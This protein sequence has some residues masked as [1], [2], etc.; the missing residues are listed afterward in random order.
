[1]FI[2]VT[3]E[4]MQSYKDNLIH[5]LRIIR[6][7]LLAIEKMIKRDEYC[8]NVSQQIRAVCG[9]LKKIDELVLGYHLQNC[10]HNAK[11]NTGVKND[12]SQILK[13]FNRWN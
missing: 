13:V 10:L 8:I 3:L 2:F 12:I 1:M 7:H 9:A 11:D 4:R 6:G 5:R